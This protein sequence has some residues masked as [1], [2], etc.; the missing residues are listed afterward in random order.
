MLL[1][2]TDGTDTLL[3]ALNL[4]EAD[5]LVLPSDSWQLVAGQ[6]KVAG[7]C[8]ILAAHGWCVLAADQQA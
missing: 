8:V 7:G 2:V 1:R 5:A 6:G 3:V 4:G